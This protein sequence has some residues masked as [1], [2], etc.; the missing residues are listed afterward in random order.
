[1]VKFRRCWGWG[2]INSIEIYQIDN[3]S[4]AHTA[5][6]WMMPK[7]LNPLIIGQTNLCCVRFT[8]HFQLLAYRRFW[9]YFSNRRKVAHS[10]NHRSIVNIQQKY[11]FVAPRIHARTQVGF[12]SEFCNIWIMIA[13]RTP[14][15]IL[16]LLA[17]DK[18]F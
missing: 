17:A 4:R 10:T 3:Y 1:M 16:R 14:N 6:S 12:D 8:F 7:Y 5:E 15:K 18:Q 11:I 13:K 9:M 2:N